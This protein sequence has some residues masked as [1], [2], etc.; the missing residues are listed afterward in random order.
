MLFPIGALAV[1]LANAIR[2]TAL[3]AL[4]TS[5]SPAVAQGGFHSQ[6][7]WIAFLLVGPGLIA[8]TQQC[9]LFAVANT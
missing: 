3:V 4:G 7:G 9:R 1:W 5:F 8:Y 6:A 2:I